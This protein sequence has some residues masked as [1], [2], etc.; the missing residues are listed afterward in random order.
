MRILVALALVLAVPSLVGCSRKLTKEECSHLL[1]RGIALQAQKGIPEPVLKQSGIY[2]VPLDVEL[3]H[4][5]ARGQAKQAIE[6]FDRACTGLETDSSVVLCGRRAKNEE[7]LRACGGMA[8]RALEAGAA[9][10]VAVT[11]KFSSDECS[12][13][14]EHG[15]QI[16]AI[17]ADDVGKLMKEC[18]DWLE[19]GYFECRNAAKDPAAWKACEVP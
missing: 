19:I 3:V 4:K 17:T 9:A 13:Y 11:R 12:H 6:D 1:G 8:A 18:E 7:E 5:T 16:G 15:V 14:A 10:R 2:G